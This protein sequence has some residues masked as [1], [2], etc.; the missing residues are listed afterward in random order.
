MTSFVIKFVNMREQRFEHLV[1]PMIIFK[2]LH[3]ESNI[4][5]EAHTNSL[6]NPYD[7]SLRTVIFLTH[8][9]LGESQAYYIVH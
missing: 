9:Q 7:V 6:E 3:S 5:V 4:L 2:T 8:V 1:L